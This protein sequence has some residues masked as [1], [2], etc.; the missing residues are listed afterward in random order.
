MKGHVAVTTKATYHENKKQIKQENIRPNIASTAI[1]KLSVVK[2]FKE[3]ISSIITL[4]K[5][6]GALDFESYQPTSL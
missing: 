4:V 1:P 5:I 2:P 6:P 3:L